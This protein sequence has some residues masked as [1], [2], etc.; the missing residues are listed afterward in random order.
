MG[1][2]LG[3]RRIPGV[4]CRGYRTG[5]RRSERMVRARWRDCG[6]DCTICSPEMLLPK[7]RAKKR[8][9]LP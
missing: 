6:N 4:R 7:F 3:R 1:G 5:T 9:H 8:E 2:I